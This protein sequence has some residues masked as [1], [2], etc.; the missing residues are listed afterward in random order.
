MRM[1]KFFMLGLAG[2]AFAACNNEEEMG[3]QFPE[4]TG[5]VTVKIVS[6]AMTRTIET[7]TTDNSVKVTGN[8]TIKLEAQTGGDEITLTA[9]EL[10]TQNKVT[11][12]N[13]NGPT[14]VTVTMND[15]KDSYVGDAP[16]ILKVKLLPLF[17]LMA[18]PKP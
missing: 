4:G 17:R 11:F 18:K 1:N 13:V 16:T 3:N 10:E 12:W 8:V 9:K 14:K 2:L 5:A 15:G 7:G 6:P